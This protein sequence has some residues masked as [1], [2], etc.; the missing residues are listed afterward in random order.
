[1]RNDAKAA[2][3]GASELAVAAPTGTATRVAAFLGAFRAGDGS[4]APSAR[5]L[6]AVVGV[7]AL[8]SLA[9]AIA[10]A[11]ASA[12]YLHDNR[13]S[14]TFGPDGTNNITNEN[15]FYRNNIPDIAVDSKRQRLYVVHKENPNDQGRNFPGARRGIYAYD[16]SDPSNP[17]PIGGNFPLSITENRQGYEQIAVNEEDGTIYMVE[18]AEECFCEPGSLLFA[19]NVEGRPLPGYPTRITRFGPLAVDPAGYLWVWTGQSLSYYAPDHKVS[20]YLPDGTFVEAIDPSDPGSIGSP[21]DLAFERATGDLWLEFSEGAV[22]LTAA[23]D[24]AFRETT[25]EFAEYVGDAGFAVDEAHGELYTVPGFNGKAIETVNE[26]SGKVEDVFGLG[27]EEYYDYEKCP[28]GPCEPR[29][30]QSEVRAMAFDPATGNVWV[31]NEG[32][33]RDYL[34]EDELLKAGRLEAYFG[35]GAS[36]ARTGP[37]AANGKTE[38]TLIGEV[39]PGEGPSVTE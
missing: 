32:R 29:V 35:K 13:P 19:W 16:I 17:K 30:R 31:V 39:G 8:V 28:N 5:R 25:T 20:K 36:N 33:G 37:P 18:R 4:G 38:A 6:G 7:L 10:A 15:S 24:Y 1:V 12:T 26:Q 3:A 21:L 34:T 2:A 11:P 14:V 27:G 23:S 22:K 9:L